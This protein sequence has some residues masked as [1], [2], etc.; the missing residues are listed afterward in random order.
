MRF[1]KAVLVAAGLMAG[2]AGV[3]AQV[4]LDSLLREMVNREAPT[5][6]ADHS[7]ACRQFS[8]YDR[9]STSAT[10]PATWFANGDVN[11]FLRVEESKAADANGRREWVMADMDGP[12]AVVRIWSANPK[13]TMRV[14]LDGGVEPTVQGKMTDLLGGK[15][16][17]GPPLSA[18]ASRG[19]NLYLPIPYAKH[20]KIT[21]DQDGFYYQVNYRTYAK[22][23]RVESMEDGSIAAAGAAIAA[24]QK[25]LLEPIIKGPPQLDASTL[26]PGQ[27]ATIFKGEGAQAIRRIVLRVTGKDNAQALRSAVLK[28]SFDGEDTIWCPVG[29]FFGSGVGANVYHNRY[30]QVLADGT[31]ACAWVMPYR[32][33]ADLQLLNT[34]STPIQ[35]AA[36]VTAAPYNWTV[37]SMY[38]HSTWRFE[39]PI[40]A[41]GGKGTVDWNYLEVDGA[42]LFM[43]DSLA[44]VNPVAEWWGEGDEKI[45]VDAETFPSHFGTGTE[46]YYGYAWCSPVPFTHPFHAQPRADGHAHRDNNWGHTTVNRVRCLDAI[47]FTKKFKFDME[48]WHWRECDVAYAATTYFYALP[49]ATTNRPPSPEA[50]RLD[51]PQPPPLPPPF[52]VVVDGGTTL[53]CEEARVSAKGEGLTVIPQDMSGFGARKWSGESHLWVQGRRPGDF[54][55]LAIPATAGKAIRVVLYATRS[56]DYGIVRCSLNGEA[57]GRETDL[58]SGAR[59][60]CESTGPIDLG[61]V[62][63]TSDTVRL[64]VEVVGGNEKAEGTRSFFG[65]DCIVISLAGGAAR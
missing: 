28:G 49:G 35:F 29:D 10:N 55:E 26:A 6:Q 37:R 62:T 32:E 42:G 31:M 9:A 17:V 65:L 18:E 43:G 54:V 51:I 15:T 50:S 13:G 11:Q 7:Y 58:F 1:L 48:V 44:V 59:G 47:P 39:Y 22:D 24:V 57:A 21:S 5:W 27:S 46:D 38:F 45:Y 2:G 52:K 30:C 3:E 36:D 14:Y 60:K 64:R 40:H 56:W 33:A 34:G 12:G 63:P 41:Y 23:T 53:E 61:V 16:P 20:C 4:T 19:W 25:E 8:S